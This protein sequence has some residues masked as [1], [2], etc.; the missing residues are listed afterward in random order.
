MTFT[1]FPYIIDTKTLNRASKQ[2][3]FVTNY[4][5]QA[6][7]DI[8]YE[9]GKGYARE[10]L[11]AKTCNGQIR[12][13]ITAEKNYCHFLHNFDPYLKMGPVQLEVYTKNPYR[14]VFHDFLSKKEIHHI[15]NIS[16]P[17]LS[18]QRN[19]TTSNTVGNAHEYKSGERVADIHK[20]NQ[21]WFNGEL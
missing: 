5:F 18:R 8:S 1:V 7:N 3:G 19:V 21:Y 2:P 10:D 20:T 14:V 17:N 12:R 4:E 15:I 6:S 13:N 16:L 11:I 9:I